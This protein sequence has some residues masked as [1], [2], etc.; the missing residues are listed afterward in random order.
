LGGLLAFFLEIK[1]QNTVIF[2]IVGTKDKKAASR[3]TVSP[4]MD[5]LNLSRVQ[6]AGEF[7]GNGAGL[8]LVQAPKN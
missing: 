4:S 1:E 7:L 2:V 3:L 8:P 5:H 6:S